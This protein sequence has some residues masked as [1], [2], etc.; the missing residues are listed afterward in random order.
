MVLIGPNNGPESETGF[1]K[2]SNIYIFFPFVVDPRQIIE[3]SHDKDVFFGP[4][5]LRLYRPIKK[6]PCFD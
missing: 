2:R 4:F 3:D 5:F 1:I 6:V